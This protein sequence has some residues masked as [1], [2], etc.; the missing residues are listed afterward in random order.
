MEQCNFQDDYG[1]IAQRKSCS[2]ASISSFSMDP[3]FFPYGQIIPKITTFGDF[4]FWRL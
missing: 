3:R 4:G 2:C 1:A